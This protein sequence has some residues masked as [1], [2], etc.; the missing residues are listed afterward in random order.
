MCRQRATARNESIV[1]LSDEKI[2][3]TDRLLS[4][5]CSCNFILYPLKS[6]GEQTGISS[7]VYLGEL[8]LEPVYR[9]Q[10]PSFAL[11]CCGS[12]TRGRR[13][14]S[15]FF[16][17][18]IDTDIAKLSNRIRTDCF[19]TAMYAISVSYRSQTSCW[20]CYNLRCTFSESPSR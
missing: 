7:V 2:T 3:V 20:R 10:P 1:S 15:D 17:Y 4:N 12:V 13:T 9:S 16:T 5:T 11:G 19:R 8:A 6:L 18:D 14:G